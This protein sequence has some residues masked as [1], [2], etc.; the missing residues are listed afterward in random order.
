MHDGPGFTTPGRVVL[1]MALREHGWTQSDAELDALID[2]AEAERR[3]KW[4]REAP[5]RA[6][7]EEN[8]RIYRETWRGIEALKQAQ[9]ND[10]WE[11]RFE[12]RK[13]E[14]RREC[15]ESLP[16][17]SVWVGLALMVGIMLY[18]SPWGLPWRPLSLLGIFLTCVLIFAL[19]AIYATYCDRRLRD[20]GKR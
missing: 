10:A 17:T 11:R 14:G 1:R 9:R 7:H 3:A 2:E 12:C 15:A 4:I 19:C 8:A 5:L 20:L 13:W 16:I 18:P 6:K